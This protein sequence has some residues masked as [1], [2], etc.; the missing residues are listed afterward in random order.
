MSSVAPTLS[1]VYGLILGTGGAV[2]ALGVLLDTAIRDFATEGSI[3][4]VILVAAVDAEAQEMAIEKHTG[5]PVTVWLRDDKAAVASAVPR[6]DL[7]T[8]ALDRV[9]GKR[10]IVVTGPAAA[11]DVIP[12]LD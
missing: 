6:L 3:G 2:T 11:I 4:R 10:V 9:R 7:L 8:D 1:A 5:A 12:L